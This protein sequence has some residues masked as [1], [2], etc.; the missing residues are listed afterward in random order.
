MKT[1]E[2]YLEYQRNYYKENKEKQKEKQKEKRQTNHEE[3]KDYLK[4]YWVKNSKDLKVKRLTTR[5]EDPLKTNLIQIKCRS[6][7]IG[8]PFNLK[9]EDVEIPELCPVFGLPLKFNVGCGYKDTGFSP[10]VDRIIPELGYI[11]GNIQVISKK[12]NAMKSDATPEE[13][14]MFAKWVLKT[15]PEEPDAQT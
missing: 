2:E 14:R 6:K 15:F 9:K 1:R 3:Y 4:D 12:A 7:K 13:L 8:V 10:S 11:K 5:L